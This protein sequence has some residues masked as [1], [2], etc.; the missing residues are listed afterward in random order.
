MISTKKFRLADAVEPKCYPSLP[1][2]KLELE[3]RLICN[4]TWTRIVDTIERT[5]IIRHGD[6]PE[7]TKIFPMNLFFH[8]DQCSHSHL[9]EAEEWV[10][11]VVMRIHGNDML[12]RDE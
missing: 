7:H 12:G 6:N 4:D 11:E 8:G 10:R 2:C 3:I 5:V 9:I 1:E